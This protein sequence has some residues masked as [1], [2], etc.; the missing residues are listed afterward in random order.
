MRVLILGGTVFL[1]RHLA[2]A[3]LEQGHSVTLFNRGRQ[4]EGLFPGAEHLRGDRDG[5]LAAL[6]G[7]RWDVA[8]DTS[9]YV[10][11]V[12]RASAQM[13]A[14]V[15]EHYTFVSSI[16]V[17][18]GWPEVSRLDESA[19]VGTLA[20]ASV[21]EIN[22]ETYGP[23]KSLCERVVAES[24]PG[25]ALIVRPGLIVGPYDPTDRFSYWPWRV[26]RGGEVLAPGGPERPVQVID[27]R[28]L[29][30]WILRM[31]ADRATGT[32]NATGPAYPL[33]MAHL[34]AESQQVSGSETTITWIPDDFLKQQQVGEWVELPLWI[35][36]DEG[37]GVGDVNCAR[38]LA[39]GLTFR[40][41]A[42]TIH[43]TLDWLATRPADYAWKAGLTPDRE[44]EVLAAWHA[45]Q[46]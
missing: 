7:R 43:A 13:L 12:V 17:Y 2:A 1:G 9:G 37:A 25:R 15:V 20:D 16:S 39:A 5:D 30:G 22:G 6:Q 46:R 45:A 10:P 24:L 40:P 26:A 21:E 8:I 28:D 34:L 11:R 31:A 35:P 3:A 14:D 41:L 32:Y 18:V 44:A 33:T 27:A 19:P 4:S 38:A 42:E 36:E 29:A 23:L